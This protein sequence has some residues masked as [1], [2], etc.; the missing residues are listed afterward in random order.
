MSSKEF[1]TCCDLCDARIAKYVLDYAK[2]ARLA[3][4]ATCAVGARR[5]GLDIDE[6]LGLAVRMDETRHEREPA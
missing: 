1:H 4:C 5:D 2:G 6:G 3:V